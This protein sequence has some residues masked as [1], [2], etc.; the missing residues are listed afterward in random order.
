VAGEQVAV[1]PLVALPFPPPWSSA[2]LD[3]GDEIGD[4]LFFW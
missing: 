3:Q 4:K 2:L 1:H